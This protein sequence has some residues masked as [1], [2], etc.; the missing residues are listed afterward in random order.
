MSVK[1]Q[2]LIQ[3]NHLC[4]EAFLLGVF[5][6]VI[7]RKESETIGKETINLWCPSTGGGPRVYRGHMGETWPEIELDYY[8]PVCDPRHESEVGDEAEAEVVD[9]ETVFDQTEEKRPDTEKTVAQQIVVNN[10]PTFFS[11]HGNNNIQVEK[12]ENLTINW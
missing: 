4:F 7:T 9:A 1:K 5:H 10:N 6:F 3:K 8:Q 11:Q 2:D 12:I